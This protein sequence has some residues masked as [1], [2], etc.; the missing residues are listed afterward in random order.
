MKKV[1]LLTL[2]MAVVFSFSLQAGEK[3]V[4]KEMDAFHYGAMEFQGTFKNFEKHMGTFM[5]TFFSQ[6]LKPAGPV[7]GVYYND[8]GKVKE[9]DLKW[10]IA[11]TIDK[12]AEVKAPLKKAEFKKQKAVVFLHVGSY[13]TLGESYGLVFKFIEENG[14][15]AVW[16]VYD[17]Y[18][19]SPMDVKPEEL[20]TEIIIPV[21]KK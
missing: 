11:F 21:V 14:Y 8:P 13:E 4:V 12:A 20:K 16:P 10:E 18:L 3:P 19:N 9:E 15:K 5:K 17:T 2:I 1:I 6:G 7:I